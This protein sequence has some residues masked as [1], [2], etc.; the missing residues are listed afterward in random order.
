MSQTAHLFAIEEVRNSA[1][2]IARRPPGRILFGFAEK[3]LRREVERFIGLLYSFNADL[4]TEEAYEVVEKCVET[5]VGVLKDRSNE[6]YYSEAV[7]KISEA[8]N[9][10][11]MGYSPSRPPS[12]E[13]LKAVSDDQA[14][15]L[16]EI[17]SV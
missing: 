10:I 2:E 4:A 12:E 3:R 15:H 11:A 6:A 8:A 5:V 9:W 17:L 13:Q 7:S 16:L 1:R 14:K